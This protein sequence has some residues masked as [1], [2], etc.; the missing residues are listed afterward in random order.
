MPAPRDRDSLIKAATMYFID[1]RSQA[2]IATTFQTSRSN[3]SRMLTAARAQNL[4]QIRVV[5]YAIRDAEL[6]EALKAR[7][8]LDL[9]LV[10]AFAPGSDPLNQVGTLAAEWL[11]SSLTH[12]QTLGLSWGRTVQAMSAALLTDR[13]RDV[14]VI[15]LVGGLSVT[16]SLTSAQELVRQVADKLGGTCRYLHAPALLRSSLARNALMDEP[17]V[18][19]EIERGHRADVAVVGIGSAG[20]GS[21]RQILDSLQLDERRHAEFI[22]SDPAGDICC[23]FFNNEGRQIPGAVYDQVLAV[24]LHE[25]RR[26]VPRRVGVASG[27]AKTQAAL[28]A[29]RGDLVNAVVVDARLAEG[30]LERTT[31]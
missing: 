24:D 31:E 2:D 17:S 18:S 5:D 14:Q 23:R 30:L 25:L 26:G 15:P 22:L 21:S 10:A 12:G 29:I 8:N 27:I 4:V 19:S 28:G 13:P 11:E 1:G 6:E 9:A 20:S 7:F 3:V 16:A